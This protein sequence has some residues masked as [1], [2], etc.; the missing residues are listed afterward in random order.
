MSR[1][2][3]SELWSP[4]ASG[5]VSGILNSMTAVYWGWANWSGRLVEPALEGV[6]PDEVEVHGDPV[7]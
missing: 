4:R 1:T 5:V 2:A 6:E 3:A 7:A